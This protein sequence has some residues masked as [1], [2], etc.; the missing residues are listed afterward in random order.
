MHWVWP[1]ADG[2]ANLTEPEKPKPYSSVFPNKTCAHS[3]ELCEV[4]RSAAR[5]GPLLYPPGGLGRDY[6]FRGMY[7]LPARSNDCPLISIAARGQAGGRPDSLARDRYA[8]GIISTTN[9]NYYNYNNESRVG[10]C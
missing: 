9:Y 7:L 2:Q 1:L 6:G 10:H 4:V 8:D 5:K 3:D